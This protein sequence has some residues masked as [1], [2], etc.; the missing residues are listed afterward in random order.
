V[1]WRHAGGEAAFLVLVDEA[2]HGGGVT[3]AGVQAAQAD[4]LA[5]L[6]LDDLLGRLAGCH[7]HPPGL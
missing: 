4:Q 3:V 2:A 5:D 6:A 1:A 7:A